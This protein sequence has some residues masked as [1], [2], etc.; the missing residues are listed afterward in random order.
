MFKPVFLRQVRQFHFLK[1]LDIFMRLL[2]YAKKVHLRKTSHWGTRKR[3]SK[4]S[5]S[6]YEKTSDNAGGKPTRGFSLPHTTFSALE[7][8][9]INR[10]KELRLGRATLT[11]SGIVPC[12]IFSCLFQHSQLYLSHRC[13]QWLNSKNNGPVLLFTT[14]G[15]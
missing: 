2:K 5:A 11:K 3:M 6:R 1:P 7:L 4:K 9:L 15:W 10:F 8:Q 14:I 13:K 12:Q